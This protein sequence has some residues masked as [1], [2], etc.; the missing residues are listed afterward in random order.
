MALLKEDGSLDVDRIRKLPFEEKKRELSRFTREQMNEYVSKIPINESH[1][2]VKVVEVD[3]KMEDLLA[4]GYNTAEQISNI[5]RQHE[6]RT[7]P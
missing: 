2:P 1:E 6:K 4:R 3:Y 5:I 7:E